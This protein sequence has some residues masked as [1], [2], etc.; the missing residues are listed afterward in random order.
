M[1]I[2]VVYHFSSFHEVSPRSFVVASFCAL[3]FDAVGA[4]E[5]LVV[6]IRTLIVR[7]IRPTGSS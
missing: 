6:P 7:V 4:M 5:Y 1:I 3:P 2:S